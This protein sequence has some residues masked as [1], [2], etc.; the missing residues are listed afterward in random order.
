MTRRQW[1]T[2]AARD[3]RGTEAS[4]RTAELLL[5]AV[6]D[7]DRPALISHPDAPV[8]PEAEERLAALV[9][10]RLTGEPVAYL[11]GR[12]EFYGREFEVDP[13]TLIPRPETEHLVEEALNLLPEQAVRFADLGTGSGCLAV[14]LAAERPLW[15]GLAVDISEDA[16]ATARRNAERLGVGCRLVFARADFTR[17]GFWNADAA[18]KFGRAGAG[19]DAQDAMDAADPVIG[20]L[21]LVVS[22]PP[23]VSEVEYAALDPGVRDFEPKTALVPGPTGLEHPR[24]V[25]DAAWRGLRPGGLLLMEHGAAQ[26][27]AT[28]G[29]CSPERWNRVETRP[30]LAGLDRYLLAVR[31]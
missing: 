18:K 15:E 13:S 14:T 12:R 17:S 8:P 31:R 2:G 27:E 5:C 26:G 22:N 10:R 16:L 11:L 24:A 30:D 28:R 20:G 23:Y 21:D 19:G 6:L 25:A 7:L 4:R 29:L 9:A 3:L 1:L